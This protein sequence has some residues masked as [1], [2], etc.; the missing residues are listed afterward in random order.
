[1][2]KLVQWFNLLVKAGMTDFS[3]EEPEETEATEE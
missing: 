1:M 3:I 2:R